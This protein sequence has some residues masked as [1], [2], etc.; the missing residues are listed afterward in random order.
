MA[1]SNEVGAVAS[2]QA[3]A[4]GSACSKERRAAKLLDTVAQRGV[5]GERDY[6]EGAA[7][8]ASA[9]ARESEG[10]EL[11][12]GAGVCGVG[13]RE[14]GRS[15]SSAGRGERRGSGQLRG[16]HAVLAVEQLPAC[17]AKP[18][19]SLE[20]WLGWAGRWAC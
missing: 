19:S 20:R 7:A 6:G 3:S 8:V 18:S 1:R 10:E 17:L 5:D 13:E 2:G 11:G 15:P 12:G 16:T 4:R 14:R 9:M